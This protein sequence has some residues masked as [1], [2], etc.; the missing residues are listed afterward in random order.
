MAEQFFP[1]QKYADYNFD[2]T[3]GKYTVDF[4]NEQQLHI[5]FVQ[6][7]DANGI[8]KIEGT[9]TGEYGGV[10]VSSV[11]TPTVNVGPQTIT[12]PTIQ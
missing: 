9:T 4:T 2:E 5:V 12:K 7:M 8:T 1:S 11:T 3:T 6:T 10:V